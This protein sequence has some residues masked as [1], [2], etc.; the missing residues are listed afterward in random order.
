M[1][2]AAA[3]L[4]SQISFEPAKAPCNAAHTLQLY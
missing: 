4:E 2:K 3:D 1:G